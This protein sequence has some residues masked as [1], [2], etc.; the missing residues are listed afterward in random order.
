MLILR[1]LILIESSQDSASVF[2]QAKQ[3]VDSPSAQRAEGLS[4]WYHWAWAWYISAYNPPAWSS[5]SW[6]PIAAMR[7]ASITTMRSAMRA[8]PSR[9]VTITAVLS[10]AISANFW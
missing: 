6:V 3:E 2:R 4:L 10:A 8:E 5:S 7:P 1:S 9:W